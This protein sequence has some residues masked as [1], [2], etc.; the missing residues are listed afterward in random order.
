MTKNRLFSYCSLFCLL[1][2]TTISCTFDY[3]EK[4]SDGNDQPDLIMENV[5]YV[6]VKSANPLAKLQA[7]RVERYEKQ[8]M[9][10]L[11][12]A[13]FEQY[14]EHGEAVNVSGKTG[15]ATVEIDSGNI[16]MNRNVTVE[17]LTEDI[18]LETHQ[19]EWLN[20]SKHLSTG[21]D[22]VYVYRKNGTMFSGIGLQSDT[23]K[24]NWEFQ[25]SV[26]GTYIR[27]DE[28]TDE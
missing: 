2:L 5:E 16:F 22:E 19:L 4:E 13:T 8:N 28:D 21:N 25:G 23:R 20:E 18:I 27:E 24:R 3:G 17:V 9:I 7:E 10:K 15:N 11:E 12:N 26:R 14:G 6:R 1:A